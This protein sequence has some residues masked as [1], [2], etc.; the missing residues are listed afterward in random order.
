MK[1]N[2]CS[3]IFLEKNSDPQIHPRRRQAFVKPVAPPFEPGRR[4]WRLAG[5]RHAW[6]ATG[7]PARRNPR[8]PGVVLP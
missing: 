2:I 3:K 5:F 7:T 4:A 6:Q 8:L 1:R